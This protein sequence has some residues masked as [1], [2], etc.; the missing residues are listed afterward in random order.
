GPFIPRLRRSPVAS[1]LLDGLNVTSLALMAGVTWQL[2]RS[3]ILDP[4]SAIL[5]LAALA[6][7]IR[8]EINAAWLVIGGGTLGLLYNTLVG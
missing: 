7:L 3:A 8:F 4:F 5:A 1:N 2:G 6:T